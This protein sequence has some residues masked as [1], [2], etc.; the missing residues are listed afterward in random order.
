MAAV[1]TEC[2]HPLFQVCQDSQHQPQ[3]N[4]CRYSLLH[5]IIPFVFAKIGKFLEGR[6]KNYKNLTNNNKVSH[7]PKLNIDASVVLGV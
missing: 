7:Q 6:I 1:L 2:R 4:H 3:H 5:I